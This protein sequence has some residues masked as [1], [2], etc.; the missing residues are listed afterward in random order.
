MQ[1]GTG[2][3]N[4]KHEGHA[5][6]Y[7]RTHPDLILER[8]QAIRDELAKMDSAYLP[9]IKKESTELAI[10]IASLQ[11]KIKKYVAASGKAKE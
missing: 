9:F 10:R 7:R 1:S 2:I 11:R 3:L 5:V 6:P 4:Q 8:L